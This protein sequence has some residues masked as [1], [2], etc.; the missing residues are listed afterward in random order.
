MLIVQVLVFWLRELCVYERVVT[1][2]YICVNHN[3]YIT[4][5]FY[6]HFKADSHYSAGLV[7]AKN[8]AAGESIG[9]FTL[10]VQVKAQSHQ[11]YHPLL[12]FD[13]T[14]TRTRPA[15]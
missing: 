8:I 7:P 12:D 6:H 1:F 9:V 2:H 11:T 14:V 4:S 3:I 10:S 13:W 5:K 15:L